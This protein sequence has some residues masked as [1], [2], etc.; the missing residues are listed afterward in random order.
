MSRERDHGHR[1][2]D[3]GPP[4]QVRVRRSQER[5]SVRRSQDRDSSDRDPKRRRGG[6][7]EREKEKEKSPVLDRSVSDSYAT[8]RLN[9]YL[10][11]LYSD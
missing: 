5:D 11:Y 2:G 8:P 9:G 6:D 7:A 3:M 10:L 1:N 4:G